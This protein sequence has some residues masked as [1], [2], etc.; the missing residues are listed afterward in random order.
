MFYLA[1]PSID[2]YTLSQQPTVFWVVN[3]V[4]IHVLD[5]DQSL[6]QSESG[7]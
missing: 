3:A 4:L 2:V 5:I 1:L 7:N 6:S